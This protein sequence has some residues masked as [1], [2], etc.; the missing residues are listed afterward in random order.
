L[1][2]RKTTYARHTGHANSPQTSQ[3]TIIIIISLIEIFITFIIIFI[4]VNIIND[5]LKITTFFILW[6]DDY[7][8]YYRRALIYRV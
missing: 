5:R 6:Q 2:K 1:K 3:S 8:R 7:L 4:T